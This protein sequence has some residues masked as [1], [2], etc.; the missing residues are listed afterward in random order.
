MSIQRTDESFNNALH[1]LKRRS[2]RTGLPGPAKVF[3][4][5]GQDTVAGLERWARTS[6][7]LPWFDGAE[8]Q[9]RFG[10]HRLILGDRELTAHR[11]TAVRT[12]E[13]EFALVVEGP[14]IVLGSRFGGRPWIW[15]SPYNW[16]FAPPAERTLPPRIPLT[17]ANFARLWASLRIMLADSTTGTLRLLRAAALHPKFTHALHAELYEQAVRPF[18]VKA[19]DRALDKL[20]YAAE[21]LES[22][23][24]MRSRSAAATDRGGGQSMARTTQPAS[25]HGRFSG[26][27]RWL[28]T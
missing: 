23:I 21:S 17:R 26:T 6:V 27:D 2:G 7:H 16:H 5:V 8:Y 11:E 20:T 4:A 3:P 18:P 24:R 22:R 12:A 14:L 19:A 13:A 10:S 15:A 9:F 25:A 28:T 1:L